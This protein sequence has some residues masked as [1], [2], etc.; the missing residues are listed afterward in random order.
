MGK[1]QLAGV[2]I[3]DIDLVGCHALQLL[4]LDDAL[5][6][7]ADAGGPGGTVA[8]AGNIVRVGSAGGADLLLVVRAHRLGELLTAVSGGVTGEQELGAFSCWQFVSWDSTL[9]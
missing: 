8:P 4:W 3:Q 9:D 6:A 1:G 2:L 5:P 7:C